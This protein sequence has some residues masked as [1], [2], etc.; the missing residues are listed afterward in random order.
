M[1]AIYMLWL[2][3]DEGN[4]TSGSVREA[5]SNHKARNTAGGAGMDKHIYYETNIYLIL[6]RLRG[7]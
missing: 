3:P 4:F 2:S 6:A 1:V 7:K 5:R